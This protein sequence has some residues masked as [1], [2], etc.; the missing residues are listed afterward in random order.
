MF[1]K[2][3]HCEDFFLKLF[4]FLEGQRN[5]LEKN[6]FTGD[7]KKSLNCDFEPEDVQ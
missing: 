3:F 4:L 6:L 2:N 5:Q 7:K 1:S